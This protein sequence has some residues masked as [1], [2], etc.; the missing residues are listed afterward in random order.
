MRAIVT[1]LMLGILTSGCAIGVK[2]DYSYPE[3]NWDVQTNKSVT[4]AVHDQRSYIVDGNK[5]PNFVGLS[6][7]GWGNPFDVVTVSGR[8]LATDMTTAVANGLKARNI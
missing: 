4:V 3:A 7:G 1:T 2:H 6:R 8:P 5:T